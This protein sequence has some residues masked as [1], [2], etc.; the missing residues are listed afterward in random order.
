MQ[1]ALSMYLTPHHP[2]EVCDRVLC[3]LLVPLRRGAGGGST[4]LLPAAAGPT[5]VLAEDD[6]GLQ[7]LSSDAR[8]LPANVTLPDAA[9]PSAALPSTP[10]GLLLG[11]A[12]RALLTEDS[13]GKLW[14]SGLG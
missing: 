3:V 11:A 2:P 9:P 7:K 4:V 6:T 13:A 12:P 1:A 5:S 10:P 14:L 8:V